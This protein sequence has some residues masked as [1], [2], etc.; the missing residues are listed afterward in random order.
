MVRDSIPPTMSTD[1]FCLFSTLLWEI[2]LSCSDLS[3][4]P[5]TGSCLSLRN[6]VDFFKGNEFILLEVF[7]KRFLQS[8]RSSHMISIYHV[9]FF[10]QVDIK[11]NS[12]FHNRI[13]VLK[14]AHKR[15]LGKLRK[16]V[17]KE[18]Y[19]CLLFFV[20]FCFGFP[21]FIICIERT[22]NVR[23]TYISS[24]GLWTHKLSTQCIVSTKTR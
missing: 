15:M 5:I 18:E 16:P 7:S 24:G 8:T 22:F 3:Q 23:C 6:N 2:S 12:L 11:N 21:R 13:S 20:L 14:M 10:I 17:D 1:L 19:V 9:V 4:E